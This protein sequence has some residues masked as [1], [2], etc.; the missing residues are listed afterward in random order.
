MLPDLKIHECRLDEV[1]CRGLFSQVL[2]E[3]QAFLKVDMQL[4]RFLK[5]GNRFEKCCAFWKLITGNDMQALVY[6]NMQ[7]F[8]IKN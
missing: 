5:V 4:N 7:V 2:K 8:L 3:M 6:K 1:A